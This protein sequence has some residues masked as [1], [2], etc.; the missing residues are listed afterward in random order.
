M[1]G[2]ER[3]L[4]QFGAVSQFLG[5]LTE[6]Y[7]ISIIAATLPILTKVFLPVQMPPL[8]AAFYV[9]AT[10]AITWISRPIGAAIWGHYSDRLGRRFLM[11]ASMAGMAIV[12][13]LISILPTYTQAGFLGFS[14]LVIIRIFVG[15]FYGG[16]RAAGVPYAQEFTPAKW[17]GFIGGLGQVGSGAGTATAAATTAAMLAYFGNDAMIAYAWRYIFALGLIP[18]V[19]VAFVR[20]ATVESPI[21]RAAKSSGKLERAPIA[22]LLKRGSR[23]RFLQSTLTAVGVNIV[24][25]TGT[26]YI[27]P[28]M[29]SAPSRLS[30][31]QALAAYNMYAYATM[32]GAIVAGSLSQYVGRKRMLIII[33]IIGIAT[34]VPTNYGIVMLSST[35]NL[36]S[37][38]LLACWF[39]ALQYSGFA[40][41]D[42]YLTERFGTSHRSSGMGISYALGSMI[43]GL[44]AAAFAPALHGLLAGIETT[45]VWLTTGS[46]AMSGSLLALLGIFIGPETVGINLEEIESEAEAKQLQAATKS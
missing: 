18:F 23:F 7:D 28:L 13:A 44:S 27:L 1:L 22:S 41:L 21:W 31:S 38:A 32:V 30:N 43:G 40:V 4:W 34:W 46:L 33:T 3:T 29:T 8:V 37:V 26:S 17:R 25:V 5:V 45:S 10:L 12:T 9:V 36:G 2:K 39:G 11:I 14:L 15:I 24:G 19:I 6:Y 16:E 42:P 35:I 20:L